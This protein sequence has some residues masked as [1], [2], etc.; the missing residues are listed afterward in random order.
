MTPPPG[1]RILLGLIGSPIKS[2]ASPAMHEAAAKAAGLDGFYHLIDVPDAGPD[3]LRLML[4]GVR[5]L[6]FSG[7]NVTFPY[8]EAVLPLLDGLSPDAARDRRGEY[9]R[10]RRGTADRPQHGFHR[11]RAG[12]HGDD[13]AM[14]DRAPSP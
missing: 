8:K 4:D 7:V 13:P 9:G 5:R 14:R 2:S 11:V 3:G 12:S 10:G 6:G 1:S